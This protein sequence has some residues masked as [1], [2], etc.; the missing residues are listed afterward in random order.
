MGTYRNPDPVVANTGSAVYAGIQKLAGDVYNFANAERKRKGEIIG[1]SLAEQQAIDD[2]VNKLGLNIGKGAS[3]MDKQ[4][5][6]EAQATKQEIARQYELMAKTFAT[7]TQIAKSKAEIARLNKYPEQLVADLSTGKYLVDQYNEAIRNAP[8][9]AGSIS[10]T[11]NVDM[12]Q[13]I[14]D[15]RDGGKNTV[16]ETSSSGARSLVTTIDGKKS[17]LNITSITNGLKSDPNY[18]LFKDV[19]D[20]SS[21]AANFM[22]AAF[23]EKP[24]ALNLIQDGVLIPD[25]D[26][27]AA[28]AEYASFQL[29][30]GKARARVGGL[31]NSLM[32]DPT[33]YGYLNSIWMDKM[34][35]SLNVNEAIQKLGKEKVSELIEDHYFEEA[36]NTLKKT[37]KL[38][39]KRDKPKVEKES[40]MKKSL[41]QLA[42]GFK[43]GG[44]RGSGLAKIDIGGNSYQI[45]GTKL[46]DQRV[47]PMIN[48]IDDKGNFT[49][50]LI[51]DTSGD[52]P[53]YLQDSEGNLIY[54]N[55]KPVLNVEGGQVATGLRK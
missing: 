5:F 34:S 43:K 37:V 3:P 44:K 33:Q 16:I 31:T 6:E 9:S 46:A 40:D 49:N 41:R 1:K 11:N 20:D 18:Q 35:N 53:L 38:Y 29:D 45:V 17:E 48:E 42:T 36:K 50:E 2:N 51:P 30:E 7:P 22:N 54:E 12:L 28:D 15:M 13:V 21:T 32:N 27:K 23:G 4:V 24:D 8:G 26:F 25:K 19:V 55:G 52:F 14:Q 47:T 39:A 10:M